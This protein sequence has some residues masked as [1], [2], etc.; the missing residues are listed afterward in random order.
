[1]YPGEPAY[2]YPWAKVGSQSQVGKLPRG[3]CD[4]PNQ[5]SPIVN[6]HRLRKT[7][8][9]K[10]LRNLSGEDQSYS[11][12]PQLESISRRPDR[13]GHRKEQG[14]GGWSRHVLI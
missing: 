14:V 5:W 4:L 13:L 10:N 11:P 7:R 9:M 6:Y 12:T 8:Y 2:Q 3:V 1:M